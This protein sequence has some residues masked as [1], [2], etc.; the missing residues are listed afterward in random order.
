MEDFFI[1]L[2]KYRKQL[3]Y[4]D[5]IFDVLQDNND[6]NLY[7]NFSKEEESTF[8]GFMDFLS[9][10]QFNIEKKIKKNGGKFMK[11]YTIRVTTADNLYADYI[12]EA[13]NLLEA[14]MQA[15]CVFFRD[16]PDA[17]MNIKLSLIE[18]N[19]KII[20]EILNIIKEANN[21]SN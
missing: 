15:E 12:V 20:T 11:A 13:N 21:G 7:A 14:K 16:Y 2:N 1:E 10:I 4:I 8:I 17:N 5:R 9:D 6:G 19:S 18:P 3:D